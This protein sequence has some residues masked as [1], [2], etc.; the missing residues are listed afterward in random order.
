MPGSTELLPHPYKVSV[1]V[2]MLHT[3]SLSIKDRKG[4][5]FKRPVDLNIL[6]VLTA[7]CM[8]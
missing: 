8:L 5:D 7:S 4:F 1:Q 2:F 6:D 3:A